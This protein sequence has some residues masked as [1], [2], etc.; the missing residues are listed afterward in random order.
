MIN[1][2]TLYSEASEKKEIVQTSRIICHH[3][4]KFKLKKLLIKYS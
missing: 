1:T 2:E 4:T 3:M